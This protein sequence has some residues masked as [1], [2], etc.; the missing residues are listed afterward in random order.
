MNWFRSLLFRRSAHMARTTR[1]RRRPMLEVLEDRVV[2]SGDLLVSTTGT[3]PQQV[4]QE[5]T[6]GGTLVRTVHIPA[7]PGTS[8]DTARDLVQDGSG[9]VYVYN[10]T[11]TPALA[12]YNP[13]TSSWSQQGYSGWSTVNNVSY[14]GIGLFQN[15]VFASDMTTAGDP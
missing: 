8:S 2:P 7:P 1:R 9:K 13:S 11:F 15:Y 4:F 14:G 6:A 12:T 3:Y 10:G 5:F